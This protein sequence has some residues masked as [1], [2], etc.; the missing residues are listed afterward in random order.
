MTMARQAFDAIAHPLR[1]ND[2]RDGTERGD[3]RNEGNK[4]NGGR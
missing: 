2:R 1:K 4:L 3:G